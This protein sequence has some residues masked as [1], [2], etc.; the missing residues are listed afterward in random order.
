MSKK[1]IGLDK[2][3]SECEFVLRI[4]NEIMTCNNENSDHYAHLF[5]DKHIA[6]TAFKVRIKNSA[7]ILNC[8]EGITDESSE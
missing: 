1:V 4:F 3:C 6:C 7:Y 8:E 5:F 2:S